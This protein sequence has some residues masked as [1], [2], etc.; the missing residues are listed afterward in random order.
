[1]AAK[2]AT[3]RQGLLVATHLSVPSSQSVVDLGADVVLHMEAQGEVLVELT[4]VK[5]KVFPVSHRLGPL[6]MAP[7]SL[8]LAEMVVGLIPMVR[9]VTLC[10]LVEAAVAAQQVMVDTQANL[11]MSAQELVAMVEPG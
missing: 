7:T 6:Q 9:Q 4:G 3:V 8:H 11:E 1:M 5:P 10:L 2:G